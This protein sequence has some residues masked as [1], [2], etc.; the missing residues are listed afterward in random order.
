L[1]SFCDGNRSEPQLT[2]LPAASSKQGR[3]DNAKKAQQQQKPF[4][5]NGPTRRR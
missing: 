3:V 5:S 2:R 4:L 1:F